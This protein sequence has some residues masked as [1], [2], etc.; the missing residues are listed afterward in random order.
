MHQLVARSE[1]LHHSKDDNV[2]TYRSAR[3]ASSDEADNN[4]KK[5]PKG[6]MADRKILS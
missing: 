5:T 3:Y 1:D 6:K 2:R 4:L